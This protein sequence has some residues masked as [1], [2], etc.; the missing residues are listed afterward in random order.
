MY[1]S[2]TGPQHNSGQ[3]IINHMIIKLIYKP[4]DHMSDLQCR[5]MQRNKLREGRVACFLCAKFCAL[6]RLEY[7]CRKYPSPIPRTHAHVRNGGK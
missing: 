5:T 3:M 2:K 1:P 7:E 4:S 6:T